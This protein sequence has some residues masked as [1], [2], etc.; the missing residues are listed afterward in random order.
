MEQ[1]RNRGHCFDMRGLD[2]HTSIDQLQYE[3]KSD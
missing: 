2:L 3:D 1:E